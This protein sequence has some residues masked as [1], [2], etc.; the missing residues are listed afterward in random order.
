MNDD[1]PLPLR[2]LPFSLRDARQLD[3]SPS[4]LRRG[5]LA[6][7]F[8]GVRVSV[9]GRLPR[10]D[11]YLP[12]LRSGHVISHATAAHL[13]GLWLPL[14][15]QQDPTIDVSAIGS[16]RPVRMKGV[17]GH[18]ADEDCI[19]LALLD[20]I[21]VTS[22]GESFRLISPLLSLGELIEAGDS[23]IRRKE[24]LL[25]WAELERAVRR[26]S[27][28]RGA[29]KLA[30]ALSQC[31]AGCDS[32]RETRIR[33]ILVAHGLP[34]PA[35]NPVVSRPGGRV[36]YGD[37]VYVQWKVIVEYDGQHHRTGAQYAADIERLEQLAREGWTVI[38][39]LKEHLVR[40]E[41]IAIRVRDALASNGW[42]P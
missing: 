39:V 16:A 40:P 21:P 8:R 10:V 12:I 37:M 41:R 14:R 20:G 30:A 18:H 11:E 3:I 32:P 22:P 28:R 25:S 7:P 5:D 36:R 29:K 24:P 19:E 31:R 34:E 27:G 6:R 9:D 23:L 42:R 38:R 4:R 17:R 1:L 33:L 13:W 35:V 2:H 15:I 26:H